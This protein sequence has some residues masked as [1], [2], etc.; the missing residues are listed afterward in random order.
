M[1]NRPPLRF[2]A[3]GPDAV[4]AALSANRTMCS[5]FTGLRRMTTGPTRLSWSLC[6]AGPVPSAT[7]RSDRGIGVARPDDSLIELARR[8]AALALPLL[9]C[10]GADSNRL[11]RISGEEME[12]DQVACDRFTRFISAS[13]LSLRSE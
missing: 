12:G 7:R 9:R 5:S 6:G 13:A 10:G 11:H 8:C 2:V 4:I 3:R 1:M